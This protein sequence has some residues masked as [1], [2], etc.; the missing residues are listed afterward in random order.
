MSLQSY[1]D[2][3]KYVI[4]LKD[5]R[6]FDGV[7]E[8]GAITSGALVFV[9][10]AG[11][12]TLSTIYAD[13]NRTALANPITRAQFATD[14]GIKFFS[15]SGSH[16]IFVALDDGTCARYASVSDKVHTLRVNRS[17][18]DKCMVF[19][20]VANAG[21]TEVDTGLDLPKQALVYDVA[22]EVVTTDAGETVDIGTLT[23]E[24]GAD[25][26]GYASLVSTA[27]GGYVQM[28]TATTGSNEVYW[29]ATGYG[30]QLAAL[31]AGTDAAGDVGTF[32]RLN[33]LVTGSNA[34]SISYTPSGS[35]TMA[36]YGYVFFKDLR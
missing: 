28:L 29:S 33:H 10:G 21:G 22:V 32:T 19:P 2:D 34:T 7:D 14:Q 5:Q 11:T 1:Y 9:Y 35:D 8:S 25:P 23:G 3:K 13:G 12:K 4:A 17:A 26:N 31:T 16:D 15:A 36:G 6:S 20:F 30:V 18:V 24:T 27:N